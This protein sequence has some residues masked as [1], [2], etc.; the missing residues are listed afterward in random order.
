MA[1]ARL[2][3]GAGK[4]IALGGV[5]GAGFVNGF[6][7]NDVG[8]RAQE[9]LL[10][11]REAIRAGV[12]SATSGAINPSDN[13]YGRNDYYYGQNVSTSSGRTM[14]VHGDQ[15]FAMWNARRG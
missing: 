9:A 14:P 3:A 4:K 2:M 13:L 6:R 7:G 1:I 15:V 12:I 10:G 8:P 5:M 11:D